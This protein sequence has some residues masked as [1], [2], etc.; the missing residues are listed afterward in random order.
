LSDAPLPLIAS[1][2]LALP[3]CTAQDAEKRAVEAVLREWAVTSLH[4][5]G[6]AGDAEF[7]QTKVYERHCL[8][9][10]AAVGPYCQP[11]NE[12]LASAVQA[13]TSQL[14]TRLSA[15][16]ARLTTLSGQVTVLNGKVTA[17]DGR[18]TAL[19]GGVTA[20]DGKGTA[21]SGQVTVLN[22]RV[23]GVEAEMQVGN[24]GLLAAEARH[25]NRSAMDAADAHVVPCLTARAP[26]PRSSQKHGE[27]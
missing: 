5:G 16:T 12:Q 7:V 1:T 22:G 10:V 26:F 25:R 27:I 23:N 15:V 8:A 6:V 21:L 11:T 20:L 17:L 19:D 24:R 14:G 18:V 13:L 4:R 3:A 9:Q 2:T